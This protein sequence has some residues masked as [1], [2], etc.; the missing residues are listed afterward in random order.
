MENLCRTVAPQGD[1]FPVDLENILSGKVKR[2][3]RIDPGKQALLRASDEAFL[4]GWVGLK[5]K[6]VRPPKKRSSEK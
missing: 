1:L 3:R 6:Y 2:P 4:V 5:E